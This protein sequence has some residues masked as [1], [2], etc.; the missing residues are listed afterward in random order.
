MTLNVCLA[1]S[2]DLEGC[3]LL[4]G[5]DKRSGA[6][7]AR[8]IPVDHAVGTAILHRGSLSHEVAPIDAG[9]RTNL[10]M[11][12]RSTGQRRLVCTMCGNPPSPSP[13]ARR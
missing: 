9:S 6:G 3:E 11:W 8:R 5:A 4:F 10:L 2:P 1:K 7:H 13:L 12:C